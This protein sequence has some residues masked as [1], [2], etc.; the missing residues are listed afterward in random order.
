VFCRGEEI[1]EEDLPPRM[2]M[3]NT[4]VSSLQ[5]ALLKCRRSLAEI[6]REYVLL[7]LELTG[8]TKKLPSCWIS[9]ERHCTRKLDK[10]GRTKTPEHGEG[11]NLDRAERD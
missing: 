3:R 11:K 4:P 2:I 6:E 10:Y 5:E 9:I 1:M 8:A 7:A